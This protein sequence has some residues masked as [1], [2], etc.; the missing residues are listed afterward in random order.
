MNMT[1]I[2]ESV[3]TLSKNINHNYAVT[4]YRRYRTISGR[5][6]K[7]VIGV[8]NKKPFIIA[9]TTDKYHHIRYVFYDNNITVTYTTANNTNITI[10]DKIYGI[11]DKMRFIYA[12]EHIS[13]VINTYGLP[14][15]GFVRYPDTNPDYGKILI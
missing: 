14:Y 4:I 11:D 2:Y 7:I 10:E 9:E 6:I 5:K 13:D 12:Y 3:K 15:L 8:K 1:E